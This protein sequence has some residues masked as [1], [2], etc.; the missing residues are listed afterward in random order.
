MFLVLIH[1]VLKLPNSCGLRHRREKAF[2]GVV[3]FIRRTCVPTE[4]FPPEQKAKERTRQYPWLSTLFY[5][6]P[7]K[8]TIVEYQI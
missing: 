1:P 8:L 6:Y 3:G 2:F 7:R 4:T 5:V